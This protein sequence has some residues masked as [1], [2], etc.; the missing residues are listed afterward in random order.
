M[1]IRNGFISNS[2]A[3]SFI[4]K[5][6]EFNKIKC[7]NCKKLLSLILTKQYADEFLDE[8]WGSIDWSMY[9]KEYNLHD[10]D[11]IYASHI[12]YHTPEHYTLEELLPKLGIKYI[13]ENE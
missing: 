1:K 6:E 13:M 3:S 11:I 2:S 9:E 10:T 5:E 7:D 8:Y 4:I 12:D